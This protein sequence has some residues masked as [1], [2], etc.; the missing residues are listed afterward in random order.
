M[1]RRPPRSTQSRS[2]AASDVYKRQ[3]GT[4]RPVLITALAVAEAQTRLEANNLSAF[5]AA[6]A[7]WV[8]A[9]VRCTSTRPSR[10]ALAT[11]TGE[12]EKSNPSGRRPC[13]SPMVRA[14]G[15]TRDSSKASSTV[16]TSHMAE[17][18]DANA[19][20][21]VVK[22]LR[23]STTTTTPRT[24][25]NSHLARYLAGVIEVSRYVPVCNSNELNESTSSV[26]WRSEH[27]LKKSRRIRFVASRVDETPIGDFGSP[28]PTC[29]QRG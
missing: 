3:V 15:I 23:T 7:P 20:A 4:P 14:P 11:P 1:I 16:P 9:D 24:S 25:S 2:S 28:T 29:L 26:N 10:S 12:F 21:A 13:S 19:Y 27:E 6:I 17:A 22:A 8:P 5:F 18:P